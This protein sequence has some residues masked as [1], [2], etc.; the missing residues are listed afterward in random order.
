MN[1]AWTSETIATIDSTAASAWPISHR[2]RSSVQEGGMLDG[3][4]A[5]RAALTGSSSTKNVAIMPT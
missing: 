1:Q 5:S 3:V 2:S 4:Q